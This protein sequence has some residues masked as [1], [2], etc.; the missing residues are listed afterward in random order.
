MRSVR[1]DER[2]NGTNGGP[3]RFAAFWVQLV[4]KET[5]WEEQVFRCSFLHGVYSYMLELFSPSASLFLTKTSSQIIVLVRSS[6]P[7]HV[8]S[9]KSFPK[10]FAN[11]EESFMRSKT[12]VHHALVKKTELLNWKAIK[13]SCISTCMNVS[14]KVCVPLGEVLCGPFQVFICG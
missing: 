9:L 3:V 4:E 13:S 8:S 7:G 12:R 2:Q 10:H 6:K 11:L 1:E 14:L 5:A